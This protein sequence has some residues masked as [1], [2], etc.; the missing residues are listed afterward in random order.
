MILSKCECGEKAIAYL[1]DD[2]ESWV[3]SCALAATGRCR[4]IVFGKTLEQAIDVWENYKGH[5]E[6][7]PEVPA[8]GGPAKIPEHWWNVFTDPSRHNQLEECCRRTDN[9][10]VKAVR[11]NRRQYVPDIYLFKCTC[12]RSHPRFFVGGGDKRPYWEVR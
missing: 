9:K 10:T 7:C 12:G 11:S 4:S 5:E 1:A 8:K 6:V 2:G 3:V